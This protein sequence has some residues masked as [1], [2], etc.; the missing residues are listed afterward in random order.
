MTVHSHEVISSKVKAKT[1]SEQPKKVESANPG[2]VYCDVCKSW[3]TL[4]L[5]G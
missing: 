4:P 2:F 5:C 1:G 3:H